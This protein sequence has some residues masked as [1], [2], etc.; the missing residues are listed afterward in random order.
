MWLFFFLVCNI[1]P[2]IIFCLKPAVLTLHLCF[3]IEQRFSKA[4][5]VKLGVV[6]RAS[7]PCTLEAEAE[8]LPELVVSLGY[9][10]FQVALTLTLCTYI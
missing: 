7:N 9:T 3:N 10:E 1:F 8:G 4:E 6:A 2:V 5:R